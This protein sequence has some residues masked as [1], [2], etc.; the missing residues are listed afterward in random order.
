MYLQRLA[1]TAILLWMY[2]ICAQTFAQN[3]QLQSYTLEDG[4]PQSQVYDVIQDEIGYLWL[5]TQGGGLAR[6][7]GEKFKVWNESDGLL[8]NY[9]HAI[10]H[11]NDSIFIGTKRGLSIKT[12][13]GFTNIEGPQVNKILK[14]ANKTFVATDNGLFQLKDSAA[15][16]RVSVH[17]FINKS[18]VNDIVFDGG[19][20]WIASSRGLWRLKELKDNPTYIRKKATNNFTSLAVKNNKIY[21]A[22]YNAGVLVMNAKGGRR[23]DYVLFERPYRINK[24]QIID[25]QLWVATDNSGVKVVSLLDFSEQKTLSRTS[26]LSVAHIRTMI[27]DRQS[28]I[29]IA[30]SGGGLYK[31]FQNS[32]KHF[33]R[34]SG[35][36]GNRIYA[37][38]KAADGLWVSNSE[39][40][41]TR[42]DS[43]GIH[44]I[45]EDERFSEVKF[46]TIASDSSG[47]IL[48]GTEGKGILFR[49]TIEV[50]SILIDSSD[51]KNIITDT[52][53]KKVTKDHL[54]DTK[55]GLTS[56][57]IRKIEIRDDVIWVA[58]YS[59][60]INRFKYSS[61]TGKVSDMKKFGP[62]SGI[63][64]LFIRDM[65]ID[66]DGK[67]WYATKD[68]HLGYI[69]GNRVKHLG[70]IFG[71]NITINS[72]LFHEDKLYI[73]TSG[74]GV[75]WASVSDPTNIARLKGK[76]KLY[77]DNIYQLIFDNEGNL[78]AGT[79]RGVDKIVLNPSNEIVDVFHFGRNDGFLG[80]ETCLNAVDKDDE[81][82]L[83]FGAIY[84]LTQ[85]QPGTKK[86]TSIKPTLHFE[87]VEVAYQS[88]DSINLNEWTNSEKVVQLN[89]SQKQVTFAFKT[90]DIN[91]PSEVQY[92]FRLNKG[93]WSPWSFE[94]RQNF[95]GLAYGAHNFTVQSRNRRWEQS[96]PIAFNFFIQRPFYK[97]FWFQAS[98]FLAILATMAILALRYLRR[99]KK[100]NREERERLQMQ[101]HLLSLE[102]KA[103][104]LQMNP[105]F[106][107][108]VL[109][110]IKA[111]GTSNPGKMNTTINT[112]AT[113]LRETLNN[114]RQDHI[115]LDQEVQTLKK[116]IEVEQLMA[117]KPFTYDIKVDSDLDKEE[118]LIPPMLIQ[119]FVENAIRH[120]ILKGTRK[121]KLNIYFSTN[122][123]DFLHCSVIDNGM[124]IFQSQ[125]TK[126]NTDHQSMALTVTTERIESLTG[127][128]TL[129]IKEL[130]TEKGTVT[131]TEISFK[132]PLETDY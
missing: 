69:K 121:G 5:G 96:D 37:V 126:T 41:L 102:Q 40:G 10:T 104:R 63:K 109:N 110:G 103:L 99:V 116:Y 106:I 28:N 47:N 49:E 95:A 23:A 74:S 130:Q 12:K 92:R 122:G 118:I 7:D 71:R 36:K 17:E 62:R 31:Y 86:D 117:T 60:G 58:T 27:R 82:N 13:R 129:K 88:I 22:T 72:L 105:H 29:W 119:P 53:V 34:R 38:H 75:W 61:E 83:W 123:G 120:G 52:I 8:S 51:L 65:R 26:G 15:L 4:L 125:K 70:N 78:W 1:Y 111:M 127:K 113:L 50:D 48:A 91:N 44:P 43:L 18:V 2:F 76:K 101:N 90:I 124:G 55:L 98:V 107:F 33:D 35:L 46:K 57:W 73:G 16:K 32:F 59:S 68:G 24:M 64:D 11:A 80:I 67:I 54:I 42:I 30:T 45:P 114:S 6:F 97:K 108:N 79:E 81:G 21:A 9:I 14:V 131:G 77:S 19:H 25:G 112:F 115:T 84:G 128:D 100:R 87:D 56:D 89:P 66:N 20:F 85:Y 132:I 94:S 39:A 93:E 3:N